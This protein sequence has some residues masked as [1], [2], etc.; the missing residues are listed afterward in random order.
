[1]NATQQARIRAKW[2]IST[3]IAEAPWKSRLPIVID[4]AQPIGCILANP[5]RKT[6]G[7]G[8]AAWQAAG[9]LHPVFGVQLAANSL[10]RPV[11][12][13][14]PGGIRRLGLCHCPA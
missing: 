11:L 13:Q 12:P 7:S 9:R 10:L 8:A 3:V 6:S 2:P 1:M 5:G 14:T 4:R